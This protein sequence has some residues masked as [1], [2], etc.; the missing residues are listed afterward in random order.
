MTAD[1]LVILKLHAKYIQFV[2]TTTYYSKTS[3]TNDGPFERQTISVQRM[4]HLPP[5]LI[6]P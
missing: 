5:L 2:E 4:A 1:Y 3:N 6:L